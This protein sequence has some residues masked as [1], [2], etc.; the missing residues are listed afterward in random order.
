MNLADLKKNQCAKVLTI[1]NQDDDFYYRA[2][3]LGI[4]Q[5][6]WIR[7]ILK[8]PFFGDPLLF[9]I[10]NASVALTKAEAQQ[11]EVSLPIDFQE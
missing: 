10:D 4:H 8:A 7:L 2:S 5:G 11:I 9:Q 1:N 6:E 3:R